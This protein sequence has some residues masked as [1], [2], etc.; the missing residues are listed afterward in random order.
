MP[1]TGSIVSPSF[2]GVGAERTVALAV[3]HDEP[4][5]LVDARIDV[6]SEARRQPQLGESRR[7]RSDGAAVD[8][9][10]RGGSVEPCRCSRTIEHA[11]TA[12]SRSLAGEGTQE[13]FDPSNVG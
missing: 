12:A 10:S 9:A 11:T 3:V 8:S 1:F 6:A 2:Q 13:G 7:H 5:G 4:G